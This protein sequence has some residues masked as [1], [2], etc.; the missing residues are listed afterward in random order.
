MMH[1]IA[2]LTIYDLSLI[3][4][5][6]GLLGLLVREL[7]DEPKRK[8]V[9]SIKDTPIKHPESVKTVSYKSRIK[10]LNKWLIKNG[11]DPLD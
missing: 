8:K 7:I 2:G 11:Y 10:T 4:L 5:V 9:V 3:V 1:I 6:L